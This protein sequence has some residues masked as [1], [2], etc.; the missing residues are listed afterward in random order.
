MLKRKSHFLVSILA[1]I[2]F[3]VLP[4]Y[5]QRAPQV[6]EHYQKD[7]A[8]Q[9]AAAL[10]DLAV[11]TTRDGKPR[12][13]VVVNSDTSK[14]QGPAKARLDELGTKFGEALSADLAGPLDL[15]KASSDAPLNGIQ[16][17]AERK[18]LADLQI[19]EVVFLSLRGGIDGTMAGSC[20]WFDVRDVQS[21][22]NSIA[23]IPIGQAWDLNNEGQFQ[24]IQWNVPTL[25]FQI[26]GALVPK[27]VQNWNQRQVA[28]FDVVGDAD[29]D[30][31]LSIRKYLARSPG[32]TGDIVAIK[33][34][35]P[36][37][38]AP[39]MQYRIPGSPDLLSA[40]VGLQKWLDQNQI[41][42]NGQPLHVELL[43]LSRNHRAALSVF[44]RP[45]WY[46]MTDLDISKPMLARLQQLPIAN[47]KN[48]AT[49]GIVVD[50]ID[51][52]AGR[53]PQLKNNI[54]GQNV[55][56]GASLVSLMG[57][58][59]NALGNATGATIIDLDTS[60]ANNA[61]RT[62][63]NAAFFGKDGIL[64]ELQNQ[65]GFSY[66]WV[67]N[68]V[69]G[70]N[71]NEYGMNL[72]LLDLRNGHKLVSTSWNG[73]TPDAL[74]KFAFDPKNSQALA[75]YLTG[76]ALANMVSA[77]AVLFPELMFVTIT[78]ITADEV[79]KV[80]DNIQHAS[81]DVLAAD[82]GAANRV[83]H[84]CLRYRN[85]TA[86]YM[87]K[88]V[89]GAI[90][91]DFKVNAFD[92]GFLDLQRPGGVQ[93]PVRNRAPSYALLVGE[94]SDQCEDNS[95]LPAP[96][97]DIGR[98]RAVLSGTC[99]F[100]SNNIFHLTG[101]APQ[102]PLFAQDP[103][104]KKQTILDYLVDPIKGLGQAKNAEVAVFYFSGHVRPVQKFGKAAWH[105]VPSDGDKK[106]A[107]NLIDVADVIARMQKVQAKSKLV[108]LDLYLLSDDKEHGHEL[109]E[110]LN[111]QP[112]GITV[113][114]LCHGAQPAAGEKSLAALI[115]DA[116]AHDP[117]GGGNKAGD[118]SVEDL[119]TRLK[120][121]LKSDGSLFHTRLAPDAAKAVIA[122]TDSAR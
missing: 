72:T 10:K 36:K 122:T 97:D 33:R 2:L 35:D 6:N 56:G 17:Q 87:K 73:Q 52:N 27:Y 106:S 29:D 1:V 28:I 83:G 70:P 98:F 104:P 57:D 34:T 21:K 108:V 65:R 74:G 93:P 101:R 117:A 22:P 95:T 8:N 85:T 88:I 30:A 64:A 23:A 38:G 86:D 13:M 105:L 76:Q 96:M 109:I 31:I 18:I 20:E 19:D 45:L 92:A 3:A 62:G 39:A 121:V 100:N 9:C 107:S 61:Q 60:K 103:Q 120:S 14:L 55:I 75:R 113:L 42:V 16:S 79:F 82:P 48:I 47:P 115:E 90:G 84:F 69:D 46:E 43:E 5:G 53:Q 112:S 59:G 44:N 71:A 12:V 40:G 26:V 99:Q 41:K 63:N 102:D 32:V 80:S 51:L 4:L 50:P 94:C 11:L 89:L 78:D 118:V 77:R 119:V 25:T 114:S 81:P 68:L 37:T 91:A 67:I 49:V 66:A 58:L 7:A 116:L 15:V 54:R 111:N 110:S 24:N